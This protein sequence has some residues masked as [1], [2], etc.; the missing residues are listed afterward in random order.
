MTIS[1]QIKRKRRAIYPKLSKDQQIR[2]VLGD[3][4][5]RITVTGTQYVWARENISTNSD[6][7]TR[8]GEA[9]QVL[10]AGGI[11]I[12]NVVGQPILVGLSIGGELQITGNDVETVIDRGG[13]PRLLNPYDPY[14]KFV[15]MRN[16][17]LA[18]V[19]STG[20]SNTDSLSLFM[21]P[22][23]YVDDDGV[24]QSI[25]DKTEI[26]MTSY[27]PS[28]TDKKVLAVV[29]LDTINNVVDVQVS[30]EI[31]IDS[32]FGMDELDDA[33]G[34]A[35]ARAMPLS[36]WGLYQGMTTIREQD[37][38]VDVRQ[39]VNVPK[40]KNNY[41][42]SAAPTV[43]DDIDL[44]YEVGSEW[45]DTTNDIAYKNVDS[46]D[47]AA[48][49]QQDTVAA[50][51]NVPVALTTYTEA[52]SRASEDSMHGGIISLATAQPLD[53]VPTD[54][55]VSKG[56][57]KLMIVINAGSDVDGEITVTGESIN[58]ETGAS[59]PADT[60]TITVDAVST[61]GS[62]TD[63]NTNIRHSFTG[64]YITS[65]WFTGSVTLSTT[66]LTLTD[67]DVYHVS[68][69]Q[70]NDHPAYILRTFDANIYTTNAAAEF[71]AYLYS[72][73]VT[74]DKCNVTREASLNVGADGETAI[75]NRYWRLRRGN[76][77]KSLVGTTD[78]IW[79]DVFYANSPVYVE[80]VTIKVWADLTVSLAP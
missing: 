72:L 45:I 33:I 75:L 64:A 8:Y 57:G 12:P 48:V 71:D 67:V 36:A 31:P 50:T 4:S 27:V 23:I 35:T 43:N 6:G 1:S 18:M 19:Y 17:D 55:V 68:F 79:V 25:A 60:D 41:A 76:I 30:S 47:G 54:I 73:E 69:E 26:D 22:I 59:T 28:T 58:R 34:A 78:G 80:D 20:T 10:P 24:T 62:D 61:D 53:S 15:Y 9:F 21:K 29:F 52:P 3:A 42:A 39:W 5:G 77:D 44:G 7:S 65:K 11:A 13:K 66:D 40:R 70:F 56:I 49:W 74:G 46:S 38:V 63:T 14:N 16:A 32:S 2:C 51:I 37:F